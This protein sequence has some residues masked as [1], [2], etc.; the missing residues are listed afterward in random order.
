MFADIAVSVFCSVAVD[1]WPN[2]PDVVPTA[3]GIQTYREYA[4]DD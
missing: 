2:G 4:K 1:S 3:A